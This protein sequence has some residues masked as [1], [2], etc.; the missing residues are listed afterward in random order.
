MKKKKIPLVSAK[1]IAASNGTPHK[2][3]KTSAIVGESG[4]TLIEPRTKN[5]ESVGASTI[6]ERTEATVVWIP[7]SQVT[8][9]LIM[10]VIGKTEKIGRN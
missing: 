5:S 2:N 7:T 4:L 8:G 3:V 10:F 9:V 6:R 1:S